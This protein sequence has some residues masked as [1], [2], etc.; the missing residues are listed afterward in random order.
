MQMYY[1]KSYEINKIKKMEKKK[2]ENIYY[3]VSKHTTNI[4][5]AICRVLAHDKV[6]AAS[7]PWPGAWQIGGAR[8]RATDLS[9]GRSASSPTNLTPTS[10]PS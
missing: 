7:L 4:L 8:Q 5:Q 1:M 6:S 2:I 10:C 9:V 3:V